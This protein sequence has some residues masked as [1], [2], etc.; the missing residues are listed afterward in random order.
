M[1]KFGTTDDLGEVTDALSRIYER[2][3]DM[4]FVKWLSECPY[5][6]NLWFVVRDAGEIVAAMGMLPCVVDVGT[7]HRG[8]LANNGGVVK[9]HRG[10]GLFADL[11]MY[12][13]KSVGGLGMSVAVG[14]CND[15]ALKSHLAA[16][17]TKAGE[18]ELL[19]G[20]RCLSSILVGLSGGIPGFRFIRTERWK[21]WRYVKPAQIY[22]VDDGPIR[23]KLYEGRMQIVEVDDYC[24]M[25]RYYSDHE[26]V[27]IWGMKG[28]VASEALKG[29]GFKSLFTRHM[30]VHGAAV[31]LDGEYRM[32][33][34]DNDTF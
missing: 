13:L 26:C 3:F 8:V 27:D 25:F 29:V 31:G 14:A 32:D 34:C 21:W 4:L 30:I 24:D 1:I 19:S 18:L 6:A 23:F 16:G 28:T 20:E 17:W 2:P 10:S 5:G 33:L 12:A 7:V 9:K 22:Y 15:A 11:G